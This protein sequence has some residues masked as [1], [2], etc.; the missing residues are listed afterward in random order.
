MRHH[1]AADLTEATQPIRD[2]Q[3]AVLVHCRNV[4]GCVPTVAQHFGGFL[5]LAKVALHDIRPLDEQEARL[6]KRER[7]PGV[8]IDNARHHARQR[9]PDT[10][11][12]G[13]DL[14]EAGRAEVARVDRHHRRGLGRAVALHRPQ[15]ETILERRGHALRQFFRS[16]QDEL[17]AAELFRR[18]GAHV[19]LQERRRGQQ[20][21]RPMLA[22]Q[23]TNASAINRVRMIHRA[24][25]EQ[26][27]QPQ[28]AGEAKRVEKRQDT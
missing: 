9:M 21:R 2:R 5:R 12:L 10:A 26:R 4:T 15:P 17:H 27:R 6:T 23:L 13:P 28:R 14:P 8:G 18:A 25:A 1:L 11:A 7:C 16:G 22:H 3:E 20:E 24:G 19:N